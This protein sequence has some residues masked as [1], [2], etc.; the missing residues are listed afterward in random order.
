MAAVGVMET[1]QGAWN[2]VRYN[3]SVI[4]KMGAPVLGIMIGTEIVGTIGEISMRSGSMAMVGIIGILSFIL[5]IAMLAFII[6]Y[7]VNVHLFAL[8]VADGR[9]PDP[10]P[11]IRWRRTE[12]VY[13]GWSILLGIAL[14]VAFLVVALIVG[15]VLGGGMAAAGAPGV[16]AVIAGI[17]IFSALIPLY[18]LSSRF[19]FAFVDIARG[20]KMD[21]GRSW[22]LTA[23][24]HIKIF[25]AYVVISLPFIG[26]IIAI[27][28]ISALLPISV[29]LI[30]F[31]IVGAVVNFFMTTC[32]LCGMSLA[33]HTV[34]RD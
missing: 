21:I 7:A 34:T 2:I 10:A 5:V 14:G 12:W 22:Q 16:G 23:P 9:A 26:I 11:L 24:D 33:Y 17:V 15:L 28:L 32:L 18:Y 30:L 31:S 29:I 19:S 3:P 8:A 27:L 6:P 25:L 13:L 4:L 20:E 1:A